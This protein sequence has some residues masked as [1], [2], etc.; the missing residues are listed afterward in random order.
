MNVADELF[1]MVTMLE[2]LSGGQVVTD[3]TRVRLVV[4]GET[5]CAVW[6]TGDMLLDVSNL[7]AAFVAETNV[8]HAEV[9]GAVGEA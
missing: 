6:A 1:G 5:R 9:I 8:I 4:D 2:T 7:G 3:D